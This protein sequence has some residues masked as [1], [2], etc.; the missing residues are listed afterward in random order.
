[1]TSRFANELSFKDNQ[2][3]VALSHGVAPGVTALAD[4]LHGVQQDMDYR[5]RR[6]GRAMGISGTGG[7]IAEELARRL[8]VGELTAPDEPWPPAAAT[9]ATRTVLRAEDKPILL[10]LRHGVR[11]AMTALAEALRTSR[12]TVDNRLRRIGLTL[13]VKG[14][15]QRIAEELSRR[16]A[17]GELVVD[18]GD[19]PPPAPETVT[20]SHKENQILVALSHGIQP[21]PRALAEASHI[22]RSTVDNRL[23]RIGLAFGIAGAAR[24]IAEELARRLAVSE[25]IA[26]AGVWPPPAAQRP[27][28]HAKDYRILL[29]LAS[30]TA[31]KTGVLAEVL[32]IPR[33]TVNYRL[34]R[35]GLIFGIAGTGQQIVR[36]LARRLAAGELPSHP[37]PG[38]SAHLRR[39]SEAAGSHRGPIP[40]ASTVARPVPPDLQGPADRAARRTDLDRHGS[41]APPA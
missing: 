27:E 28:P 16:I 41:V 39:L 6:I 38:T 9:P 21:S 3:L 23:R 5:L 40:N 10:A 24:P 1:M 20:L 18:P 29:A 11:P 35:I 26:P 37:D 33:S 31:P 13:G 36:E 22:S 4:A 12:S 30:G 7:R 19:W 34:G 17:T 14:T 8:S 2:I 15:G 25:L 32:K